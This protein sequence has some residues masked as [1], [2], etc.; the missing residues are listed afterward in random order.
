MM[1]ARQWIELFLRGVAIYSNPAIPFMQESHRQERKWA[2]RK[3]HN[4]YQ[5]FKI[6]QSCVVINF[7]G[8]LFAN[9]K[10][11]ELIKRAC[12]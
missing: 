3:M 12:E 1:V 7:N 8:K 9:P 4:R 10:T 5:R 2:H 11:L 6:K